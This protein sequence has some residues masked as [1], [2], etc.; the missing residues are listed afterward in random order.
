MELKN[1]YAWRI[2][3]GGLSCSGLASVLVPAWS[4]YWR[5][6]EFGFFST[7]MMIAPSLS[8]S[9]QVL[10]AALADLVDLHQGFPRNLCSL[11]WWQLSELGT[12]AGHRQ[13]DLRADVF[14]VG[15]GYVCGDAVNLDCQTVDNGHVGLSQIRDVAND[16]V[17]AVA[18]VSNQ[19]NGSSEGKCGRCPGKI[20]G[21]C[22][23]WSLFD[24]R[25][26]LSATKVTFLAT[27]RSGEE[28]QWML[29]ASPA[30][31]RVPGKK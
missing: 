13:D 28:P 8:S 2:A 18:S 29:R 25:A 6:T 27:P 15:G 30:K 26:F 31:W 22:I 3:P 1:G 7:R 16:W 5:L 4:G 23:G 10:Q 21:E 20:S 12:S 14:S 19:K 17:L 9:I 11:R 24:V